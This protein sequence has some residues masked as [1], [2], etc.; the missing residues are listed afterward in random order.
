MGA[1]F[2]LLLIGVA[3]I[4][5]GLVSTADTQAA[6]GTLKIHTPLPVNSLKTVPVP[7]PPGGVLSQYVKLD[8][9]GKPTAAIALGKAL[10][11]DQQVGSDNSGGLG[12]SCATCHFQ[13]GA[14]NRS[15]NQLSP[16]LNRVT[17]DLAQPDP[18]ITFQLGDG[19]DY[20]LQTGDYPFHKLADPN[21]M[22]DP[23]TN[24]VV[25]DTNDVTSSQG[26]FRRDFADVN[27]PGADTCTRLADPDGFSVDGINTRRVEPRNAPTVINAVFN[28]RNFWDGRAQFYFNGVN[29]FGARDPNAR[30][31]AANPQ[32]KLNQVG[33]L[34]P[35]SSLASQA[36]GPPGSKFEMSCDGRAFRKI[37]KKLL[38]SSVTPLGLQTVSAQDSVLGALAKNPGPGL[39]TSYKT[40]VNNAFQDKWV[41]DTR[42]VTINGETY[43]QSEANFSLLFGLAVQLYEAT[44]VADSTPFDKFME[45]D[46]SQLNTEEQAGLALFT[47]NAKCANCHG[48]AEL[49]NASVR[50]VD[51][52]HLERMI[53]GNDGVAV[54]DN[55]FY[56]IG[57]RPTREDIG[58]GGKDPFG[59]PLSETALCI[60]NPTEND[61][62][63][64]P[65]M[66][67]IAARP[68]ENIP[69]APLAP[70]QCP[71]NAP[72][73]VPIVDPTTGQITGYSCDRIAVMG[74]FKAPGLR[75]VELT[76]PY[77][78][79]G[80]QATLRQVVDFYSRKGDFAKANEDNL[81]VDIVNLQLNPTE[82]HAL[83]AFLLK[84]TDDRVRYEKAPF[85]HPS[86][87]VPNGHP[88]GPGGVTATDAQTIREATDQPLCVN[89][90]GAAGHPGTPLGPYLG[91]DQQTR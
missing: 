56:N 41:S 35:F 26:V 24:P 60:Q 43:T 70:V 27:P 68:L 67:N 72:G 1:G 22:F 61:A 74:A 17:P 45:G 38:S 19:P 32:G 58:V 20:Q 73:S 71:A 23:V 4:G 33:V 80:G 51:K 77:F 91:L 37:G 63:C 9:N 62:N 69:A 6:P 14:D 59:K 2:G 55:G 21:A 90:V 11:W 34:I 85:D 57:V 76:G 83:V 89:A 44:L 40:M 53:L 82:K 79:N 7:Q 86:L 8:T 29:P 87:C 13:A 52:E 75:N 39:N 54:Y 18:D 5:L 31:W 30:V 49:T 12:Q 25:S 16:G 46:K 48:G 50:N 36:V 81:D 28:N 78:H 84:L 66:R 3:L 10:F 65:D 88:G 47:G 64:N 42:S 15:K